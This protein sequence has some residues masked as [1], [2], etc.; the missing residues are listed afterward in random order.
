MVAH[1]NDL[2]GIAPGRHDGT[3]LDAAMR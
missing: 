2:I 3:T 1:S